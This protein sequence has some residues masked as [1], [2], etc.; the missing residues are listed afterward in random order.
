MSDGTPLLRW[1]EAAVGAFFLIVAALAKLHQSNIAF[2]VAILTIFYC[3]VPALMEA[4]SRRRCTFTVNETV[5][6]EGSVESIFQLLSD[7]SNTAKWDPGV[8]SAVRLQ[9]GPL[10]TGSSFSLRT[11]W[12]GSRSTMTYTI[13]EMDYP[14][15][16]VLTGISQDARVKDHIALCP[17]NGS[18]SMSAVDYTLEVSLRGW[19]RPLVWMLREDL[20]KLATAA[21]EGLER[22]CASRTVGH[23]LPS[24]T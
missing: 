1:W 11:L 23:Q 10:K 21:M 6:V 19:R 14:S 2:V 13:V 4:T 18:N 20:A 17:A 7:F 5:V 15:R 3:F 12:K 16:V 24:S 8:E 22:H 9:D